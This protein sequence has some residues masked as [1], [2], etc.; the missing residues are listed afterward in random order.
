MHRSLPPPLPTAHA[1]GGG[2]CC[3]R[4]RVCACVPPTTRRRGP[5]DLCPSTPLSSGADS[6]PRS[7]RPLAAESCDLHLP[8]RRRLI[9][10]DL[11][12]HQGPGGPWGPLDGL[13]RGCVALRHLPGRCSD[14]EGSVRRPL[15]SR[16]CPPPSIASCHCAVSGVADTPSHLSVP[17]ARQRARAHPP[18]RLHDLMGFPAPAPCSQVPH[19]R[20]SIVVPTTLG[21]TMSRVWRR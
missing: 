4:C 3:R 5:R 1:R 13:L 15:R 16:Q 12:A 19:V 6:A 9:A 11:A 7:Q 18:C 17:G 21:P 2:V 10:D 8:R 20:V 14:A